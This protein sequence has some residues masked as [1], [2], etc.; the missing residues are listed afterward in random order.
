MQLKIQV[1]SHSFF[2]LLLLFDSFVRFFL[3]L[4]GFLTPTVCGYII[5]TNHPD[6]AGML[7][8]FFG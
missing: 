5:V 4:V 2:I 6:V 7:P 1:V 8:V 3:L